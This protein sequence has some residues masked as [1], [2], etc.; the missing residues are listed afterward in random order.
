MILALMK[1]M[2]GISDSA[3]LALYRVRR[4]IYPELRTGLMIYAPMVLKN[5]KLIN[6]SPFLGHIAE[7][8]R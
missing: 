8:R 5:I 7:N 4:I 2:S 1:N 3:P 6:D